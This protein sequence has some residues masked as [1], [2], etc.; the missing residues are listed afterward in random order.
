MKI[1][2]GAKKDGTLTALEFTCRGTGGAHPSGGT[3][4]DDWVVRDLYACPNVRTEM[5]DVFINAGCARPMRAPGHPQGAW[6]LEQMMDALA[7]KLG[8][9]PVAL[10]ARNIPLTSQA[11]EG[12]PPYTT[13][14]LRKCLE[15]GAKVFG[16]SEARK[17][18]AETRS[19][20]D[21]RRGVGMASALWIGGGGW[22]PATVLVKVFGDGSV[23]LNMGAADL[24]TGTKTVMAMVVAE[25]LGIDPKTIQIENADTGTTQFTNPSGGSKTVPTESPA[26]R[27][28]AI[29]VKKQLLQMA[30]KDLKVDVSDLVVKNGEIVSLTDPAK[31]KKFRELAGLGE[32]PVLGV[33]RR[34]PDPPN[35]VV[36]PF[37]AQFCEVEVNIRTGEIRLLRFV[38]AHDSGRVMNRLTYENQ[39]FGGVTMGAGLA[40]MEERILDREQTGKM[41]NVNWHDY[42]IPTAADVPADM[43]CVPIDLQDAECNSTGAKG[44]G[45]PAT[46]PAAAAIANAVYNATGIR[47]TESPISPMRFSGKRAGLD[48]ARQSTAAPDRASS[49]KEG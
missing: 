42:K 4:L 47:V 7:E 1:K 37:A 25:E 23:N 13:T 24:G 2:A 38:A 33:G 17:R 39:V 5:T 19:H 21:L 35:K 11:R 6:A 41:V 48:K 30:A 22:P 3:S 32:A 40:L 20:G 26:V 44:L 18:A 14:G 34:S 16:W 12:N 10:R 36:N 8:M 31:K 15:E 43:V 29:S 28:A 9:D 45:E 27:A 49:R 46:I